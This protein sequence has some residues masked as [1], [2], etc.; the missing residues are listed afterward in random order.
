MPTILTRLGRLN[1][2]VD[3]SGPPAVLWHSLFVDSTS[4]RRL[5]PRLAAARRLILIDGPGHGPNPAPPGPFSPADCAAAAVEVIEAL[6]VS[7]PV[8]WL[9][10]AWGGHVGLCFAATNPDACRSLLTI[11][12]PVHALPPADRR[13]VRLVYL[14]HRFAGPRSVASPLTDALLGTALRKADPDADA[15]VRTA[16]VRA[17]RHGMR[18]AIRSISL[19]RPDATDLLTSVKAPTLMITGADDAMCTP[20]DTAAW[21]AQLPAGQSLLV[22]GAGHLAPLFDPHTADIITDFWSNVPD[23]APHQPC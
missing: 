7:G 13:A 19:N 6:G 8:D 17:N 5:R 4:W 11:A 16:F 15:I 21:A 14:L 18:E 9:G 20:T 22:A 1:V 10:N 12:T 23:T 2:E 3:G